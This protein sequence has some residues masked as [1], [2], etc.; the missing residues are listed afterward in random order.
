MRFFDPQEGGAVLAFLTL[1]VAA[2]LVAH[3][4][5]SDEQDGEDGEGVKEDEVEEGLV[6]THH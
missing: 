6:G 3:E 2:A 5:Q 1:A 4:Q